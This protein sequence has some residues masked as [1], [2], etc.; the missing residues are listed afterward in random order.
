MQ[1]WHLIKAGKNK[2]KINI[3]TMQNARRVIMLHSL[4]QIS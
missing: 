3:N 4:N 1:K 2:P